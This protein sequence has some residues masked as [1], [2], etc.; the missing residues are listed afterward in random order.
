MKLR[1][2]DGKLVY[3]MTQFAAAMEIGRNKAFKLVNQPGFPS[4]RIGRRIVIPV[5]GLRKWLAEQVEAG[6][7]D[8]SK[9]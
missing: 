2:D 3:T 5:D 6:G 1:L 8:A 9:V 7:S 4:L